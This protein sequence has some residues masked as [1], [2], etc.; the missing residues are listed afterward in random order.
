VSSYLKGNY[1]LEIVEQP[2]SPT[3]HV[4][5]TEEAFMRQCRE[6]QSKGNGLAGSVPYVDIQK[7]RAN[8]RDNFIRGGA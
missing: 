6:V 3:G 5:T 7:A 1:P 2:E 8:A 4:E